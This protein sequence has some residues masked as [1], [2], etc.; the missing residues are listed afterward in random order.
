MIYVTEELDV[1]SKAIS[2]L[3]P[4]FD[5]IFSVTLLVAL[6]TRDSIQMQ[7]DPSAPIGKLTA[8]N[9]WIMCQALTHRPKDEESE[10]W[11][12]MNG[13]CTGR[14]KEDKEGAGK[15]NVRAAKIVDRM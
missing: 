6:K 7:E 14:K 15:R 2:P 1:E 12:P 11:P 3:I 10:N 8:K 13:T 9:Q 4:I 5:L